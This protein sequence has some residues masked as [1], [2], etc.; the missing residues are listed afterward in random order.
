MTALGVLA[1]CGGGNQAGGVQSPQLETGPKTYLAAKP[2]VNDYYAYKLVSQDGA[3]AETSS[4]ITASVSN[5]AADGGVSVTHLYDSPL[6]TT[7]WP[8]GPKFSSSTSTDEYD[9]LGRWLGGKNSST[10]TSTPN[11]PHHAVAPLTISVGMNWQYSIVV[12]NNCSPQAPT[13]A[14]VEIKDSAV[15]QE[16]VTVAAGTF[17]TIKV[18]RNSSEKSSTSTIVTERNCWWEPELGVEVKCVSNSTKT[19][20]ATGAASSQKE[21]WEMLGYANQKLSRKVD[22][23]VRFA[24]NWKGSYFGGVPAPGGY[25]LE[26]RLTVDVNGSARGYCLGMATSFS[27]T[28]TLGADGTLTFVGDPDY[29]GMLFTGKLDSLQKM[30]GVWSIPPNLNDGTWNL[31]QE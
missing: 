12:S 1:G 4:Y 31:T 24:G 3:A 28:G 13:Q 5:V 23:A 21:T 18:I 22:T 17:N 25:P 30:S 29:P 6:S 14:A 9:V 15:A 8:A 7:T 19:I 16:T 10:C 11:L 26:C 2:T 27:F 20:T